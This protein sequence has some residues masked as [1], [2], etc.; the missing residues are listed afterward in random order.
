LRSGGAV[1]PGGWIVSGAA[2]GTVLAFV[3]EWLGKR[4]FATGQ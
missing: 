4:Y 3:P 1:I 2:V